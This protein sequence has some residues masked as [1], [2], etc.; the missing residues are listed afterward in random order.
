MKRFFCLIL[1]VFLSA[2]CAHQ[3]QASTEEGEVL[4]LDWLIPLHTPQPP[5]DK[6]LKI[7]EEKTN[8]KLRLIWVPDSTKE[9]RINTTLAGGSMAK[10]ITL[11]NLEDS[12]VV[13]ALR[14]GMFWEIGPYLKAYPN[15]KNLDKTI[16]KN[17]SVDGKVYGIYRERPLARQGVVIRKDWLDNLGLDMPETADDIYQIAKAFTEQVLTKMERMTRS[18]L[19]TAMI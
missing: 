4:E 12:A 5:K 19:P 1:I 16:L 17:I 3:Q 14:S 11:P 2:G 7:I 15:L 18:V 8:T 9:E 13:N 6:A 10:I